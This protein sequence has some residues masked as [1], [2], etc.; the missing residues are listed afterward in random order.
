MRRVIILM[1][2]LAILVLTLPPVQAADYALLKN[3]YIQAH[4]GQAIIPF[5]W[6]TST[7][8]KVLPFDAEIPAAPGN[9]LSLTASRNEFESASFIINAQKDLSGITIGVP[10]LYSAQGNSIPADAINVRTVK[11]WYQ[12]GLNDPNMW[13]GTQKKY[14]VPELLLK[15]DSLVR[16]DYGTKT[17]YLKVTVNGVQKYIDISNPAATFPTNAQIRD[18][19]SLQPFSLKD[20]ENKQIW[21][22]V[23]VPEN[24]PAGN[25]YGDITLA[26]PS[27]VPVKMNFCVRV[28][29]F[30][31]EPAPVEYGIYYFGMLPRT[32]AEEQK[33]G[34]DGVWK[35][36]EK[37]A[38]ELQN[39]KDHGVLYPTLNQWYSDEDP[40]APNLRLALSLRSQTGLPTDTI[41]LIDLLTGNPTS[42]TALTTLKN[43]VS[44]WKRITSEY[45]YRNVY[46]YGIDE[47]KGDVLLSER[48]AWQA[49]HSAGAKVYVALG[50]GNTDAVNSVGDLLDVAVFAGP[51]DTSQAA[52]W[53]AK[54]KRIFSYAN[55]QV[56]VENPEI[57]RKNYGFALWN[58][59]Y[60]GA[61]DYVIPARDLVRVSGMISILRPTFPR[62]CICLSYDKRCDRHYRMGGVAGRCG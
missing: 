13:F 4:P 44:D 47:A 55:P 12:A 30:E 40:D 28:L 1:V 26:T 51:L 20:N 38:A 19:Q 60:D 34:I 24:T 31:L 42:T 10:D 14:L 9:T 33:V 22:T 46:V 43:D 18:A 49:V 3:E 45:G 41:Y 37:Y 61:M 35:S 23:H 29:P 62:P 15:D 57:Y 58:A 5:P 48:T 50:S 56:G 21:L 59:G 16:V 27:A 7:S 25:Y 2:T 32:T 6:E 53:H 52:K 17:N 54:G 11:V 36:P 39:M 8:I